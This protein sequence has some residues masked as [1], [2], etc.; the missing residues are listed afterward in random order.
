MARDL[1]LIQDGGD[2]LYIRENAGM[3]FGKSNPAFKN[4]RVGLGAIAR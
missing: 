4:L 1:K 2:A 3:M